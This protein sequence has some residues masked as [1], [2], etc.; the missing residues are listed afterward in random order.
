MRKLG[1]LIM[2]FLIGLV[3]M[4][5]SATPVIGQFQPQPEPPGDVILELTMALRGLV[6]DADGGLFRGVAVT[7]TEELR[8]ALVSKINEVIVKFEMEDWFGGYH[9]LN[10]DVSPK[11]AEPFGKPAEFKSWLY[12]AK[13]GDDPLYDDVLAFAERCQG[14]IA[15]INMYLT[16]GT[17]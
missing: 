5:F 1:I 3:G 16:D 4:S 10:K 14:L 11:L 9:K 13:G 2:L 17:D 12:P 15:E 6:E 7:N 8:S